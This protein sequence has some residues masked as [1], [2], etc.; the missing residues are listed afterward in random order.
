[1]KFWKTEKVQVFDHEAFSRARTKRQISAYKIAAIV[2]VAA[3]YIYMV[4]S[5]KKVPTRQMADKM[6]NALKELS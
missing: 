3:P 2:G 5:G 6:I 1:M 4:E